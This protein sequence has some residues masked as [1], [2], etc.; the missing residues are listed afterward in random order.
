[1]HLASSTDR[2]PR[3]HIFGVSVCVCKTFRLTVSMSLRIFWLGLHS[4]TY[5]FPIFKVSEPTSQNTKGKPPSQR[6]SVQEI[7]KP[8]RKQHHMHWARPENQNPFNTT[9]QA[10]KLGEAQGSRTPKDK[11][12]KPKLTNKSHFGRRNPLPSP[13]QLPQAPGSPIVFCVCL[14]LLESSPIRCCFAFVLNAF[15]VSGIG[16]GGF[17][18]CSYF[19]L[20]SWTSHQTSENYQCQ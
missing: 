14:F 7:Q 20:G 10:N 18:W 19:Q 15:W 9:K 5:G 17:P 3:K 2:G 6:S 4:R 8:L 12:R 1:M 13:Q 16:G 11:H